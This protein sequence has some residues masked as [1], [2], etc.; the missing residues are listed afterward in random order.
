MTRIIISKKGHYAIDTSAKLK[1]Q[2]CL[3]TISLGI[4]RHEAERSLTPALIPAAHC[5]AFVLSATQDCA[6]LVL[7]QISCEN[8]TDIMKNARRH[9]V[10][11][12]VVLETIKHS[13]IFK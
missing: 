3:G 13:K 2:A 7:V 5:E 11:R 9:C 8:N 12:A 1:L 10:P 4:P 6:L